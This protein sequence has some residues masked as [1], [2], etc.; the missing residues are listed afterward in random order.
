MGKR[1]IAMLA[2]L[3]A[4][5]MV[6]PAASADNGKGKGKE[7]KNPHASAG[8][9]DDRGWEHRGGYEYRTYQKGERPPGWSEGK[10]TGWGDCDLP[11]GQA[12]KYGCR[13]YVYQGRHH[14]YYQDEKGR[15]VVRRPAEEQGRH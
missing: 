6:A 4:L 1:L 8:M 11:P 13:T 5:A 14:Y 15:I 9:N 2:L 10:K 12:K 7:K 3:G